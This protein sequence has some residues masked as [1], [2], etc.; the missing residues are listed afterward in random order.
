MG[1]LSGLF[2]GGGGGTT[3]QTYVSTSTNVTVSPQ[4]ANVVEV[5]LEKLI[6]A[7]NKGRSESDQVH[8]LSAV[9]ALTAAEAQAQSGANTATAIEGFGKNLLLAGAAIAAVLVMRKWR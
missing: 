5:P 6:D 8:A 3:Q 9:A 7:L 1:F 2:G 4:I